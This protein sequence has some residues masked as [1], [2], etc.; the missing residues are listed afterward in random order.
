MNRLKE[1]FKKEITPA[2][3]K[4]FGYKNIH[5]VPAIDKISVNMGVGEATQN[6][7]TLDNAVKDMTLITGRK[8]VI[9]IAKKS[10]SN[11]KLRAG[12]PIGCKVTLRDEAMYEFL[13][14]LI[15]VVIPRI[16]DFKGINA[17]AFDGRGNYSLGL[18]EQIVFP[19]IEYDKI[20]K[21]RGMN[22]NIVTSAKSDEEAK[23]LLTMLGMPFAKK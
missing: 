20:D 4:K 15:A 18:K 22:I 16:R 19:E 12:N 5:Q 17:K 14:K 11:F 1:K 3:M 6:K 9:T 2:L 13:D 10:I 8:P 23:E 7:A 21:V